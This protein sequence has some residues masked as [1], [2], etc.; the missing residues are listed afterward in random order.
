MLFLSPGLP[1]SLPASSA[2]LRSYPLSA[3]SAGLTIERSSVHIVHFPRIRLWINVGFLEEG[4]A[5]EEISRWSL[6]KT[7]LVA[8]ALAYVSM[9]TERSITGLKQH[10]EW[11][12]EP[13]AGQHFFLNTIQREQ[14][15]CFPAHFL[16]SQ[17]LNLHFSY[18]I[19][20]M[21]ES[22]I[23]IC[24]F[25][26]SNIHFPFFL[27]ISAANLTLMKYLHPQPL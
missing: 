21:L 22:N 5:M 27:L 2:S 13:R 25:S 14:L 12:A 17:N 18:F 26:L 19:W 7:R 4:G 20:S 6:V 24:G 9:Q 1:H 10:S 15:I 16:V 23:S 8:F 3:F 11:A